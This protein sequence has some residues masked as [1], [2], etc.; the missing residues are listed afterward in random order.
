MPVRNGAAFLKAAIESI[1]QQTFVDFEFII[2]D[3]GSTDATPEI[4]N[5]FAKI[6]SRI[7]VMTRPPD[8]MRAALNL[9][10][11]LSNAA[12]VARMDADDI[13]LPDRFALQV[14]FLR[15]FPEVLAVGGQTWAIDE[16]GDVMFAIHCPTETNEIEQCLLRGRNCQSHPAMMLRKSAVF[17]V[18]GYQDEYPTDD[19]GL[20]LRMLELGP[21]TNLPQYL[22]QYRL[23]PQA[24]SIEKHDR[25]R[26]ATET[27]LAAVYKR[28]G[29]GVPPK[30]P[31]DFA[32]RSVARLHH[33]WAMSAARQGIWPTAKK[34]AWRSLKLEPTNLHGWWTLLKSV[35]GVRRIFG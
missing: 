18:G 15:R 22:L 4:L 16:D 13:A 19:Y 24:S 11:S 25:Q 3:D 34:H 31:N 17:N 20:W 26:Q 6:D 9:G 12:I 32:P 28:R 5:E 2:I 35:I 27:L 30:L 8:G 33:H 29:L 1:I 10:L 14:D 7:L 21:I 23:H